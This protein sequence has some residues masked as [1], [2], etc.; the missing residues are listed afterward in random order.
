[1][2]TLVAHV[3]F[4]HLSNTL[5]PA[6]LGIPALPLLTFLSSLCPLETFHYGMLF[7][8][9]FLLIFLLFTYS[10]P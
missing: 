10:C 1:M 2:S 6:L 9:L 7:A 8:I 3:W 5:S 4:S